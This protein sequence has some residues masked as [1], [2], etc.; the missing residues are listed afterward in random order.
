M[1]LRE[2]ILLPIPSSKKVE[3]F[4]Y[5]LYFCDKSIV[6]KSKNICIIILK[7]VR[8]IHGNF[9]FKIQQFIISIISQLACSVKKFVDM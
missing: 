7:E 3:F 6:K 4:E 9:N 5:Y 2:P 8:G 1:R